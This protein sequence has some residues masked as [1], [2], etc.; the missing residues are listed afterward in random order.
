TDTSVTAA[1]VD[2][3]LK[4]NG[5]NIR[6][7]HGTGDIVRLRGV[8]LGGWL[9]HEAWM[10]PMD[11]SG[12]PDDVSLRNT[13]ES[14]FGEA[15][16]DRVIATYA[17]NWITLQDLDNIKAAGLNMIRV[18]FSYRTLMDA[19]F[20][21]RAD[22]FTQ[23]DWVINEAWK[24]GLYTVLDFHGVPGG[25]SSFQSSGVNGGG[26][27]WSNS[28][29][30]DRAVEIWQ[31]IA[32]RYTGNPAIAAYDLINEPNATPS[33]SAL[34]NMYNRMYT[35][36][37]AADPDHTVQM[38]GNWD[39]NSLPNPNNF[40]WTN[41]VYHTH[42][43]VF[44]SDGSEPTLAQL[45]G[46]VNWQVADYNNHAS[47]NVPSYVGEFNMNSSAAAWNYAIDSFNNN[48][49]SW[50]PW[51]YKL[52][53]WVGNSWGLYEIQSQWPWVPN[54]QTDSAANIMSAYGTIR[55]AGRYVINPLQ[56]NA[57]G[58]PGTTSDSYALT[59]GQTLSITSTN[60]VLSNDF[61]VNLGQSGI[62][63]SATLVNN[64]A[65]GTLTLAVNGS[66]T[67]TPAAGFVGTDTFR[68]KVHDGHQDSAKFETVS[69]IVTAPSVLTPFIPP[70]VIARN[71]IHDLVDDRDARPAAAT[72][73]DTAA[74]NPL[75][76]TPLH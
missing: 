66:F 12:L 36:I 65:H 34:W 33:S 50:T 69:L 40:G 26:A 76:I 58:M 51:S 9:L 8:N 72:I 24:R 2:L 32:Q 3:F 30:Q 73:V 4:T 57:I 46:Q 53:N 22:A 70:I 74:G 61:D 13:L 43:Y 21:W 44:N 35:T 48:G 18:P 62:A 5:R 55:T 15:T 31:R 25:A 41:I 37:R 75:A 63:L 52:N 56:R 54:V 10:D 68:Y 59:R 14:R 45:Q 23:M 1:G 16:A 38:E 6:T 49:M 11:N 29:Y 67:Y 71:A 27:F 42:A 20:N 47:W 7:A 39:W 28:T 64:V 60:G 19:S 17:S